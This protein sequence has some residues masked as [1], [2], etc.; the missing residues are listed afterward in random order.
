MPAHF[1]HRHI[2]Q[3]TTYRTSLHSF[4]LYFRLLLAVGSCRVFPDKN[5]FNTNINFIYDLNISIGLDHITNN[6][7]LNYG[8][9]I[10]IKLVC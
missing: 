1:G 3:L 10:I 2:A 5:L 4:L 9:I 7:S 8:L 6:M